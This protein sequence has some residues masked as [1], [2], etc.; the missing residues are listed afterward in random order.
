[1][2]KIVIPAILAAVII[3]AGFVAFTPVLKVAAHHSQVLAAINNTQ[4]DLQNDLNDLNNTIQNIEVNLE[5]LKD[6]FCDF[7]VDGDP[8]NGTGFF[9]DT[10]GQCQP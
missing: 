2:K 9:N 3:V 8:N 4:Q 10:S 6:A 5:D 1:M 7:A